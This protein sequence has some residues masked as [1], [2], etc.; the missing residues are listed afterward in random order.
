MPRYVG[1]PISCSPI[2]PGSTVG[3]MGGG[4]EAS[5]VGY[6][7]RGSRSVYFAGD[8]DLFPAMAELAGSVDIALLPVGG[9]GPGLGTVDRDGSIWRRVSS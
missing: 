8:T 7:V 3:V 4:H 5:A 9:W 2:L 6:V 1:P